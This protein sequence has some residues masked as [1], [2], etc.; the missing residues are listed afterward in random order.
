[1]FPSDE[2]GIFKSGLDSLIHGLESGT[3]CSGDQCF[4]KCARRAVSFA[5]YA[6]GFMLFRL[7]PNG[8]VDITCAKG[9]SFCPLR[10]LGPFMRTLSSFVP[11]LC[12]HPCC[13]LRCTG[14]NDKLNASVSAQYRN[15]G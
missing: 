1:M 3:A 6:H 13:N 2:K 5:L 8:Y 7:Y 4:L 14:T 11:A 12:C 9:Y 10:T 15:R